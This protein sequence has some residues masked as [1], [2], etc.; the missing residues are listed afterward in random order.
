MSGRAALVHML[1]QQLGRHRPRFLTERETVNVIRRL[2]KHAVPSE[3][4]CCLWGG[5]V[6]TDGYGRMN[7]WL[8]GRGRFQISVHRLVYQ[9]A[10]DPRDI[11]F[12]REVAHDCDTPPCFHP[13]HVKSQR[14]PD[15]RRRS[16]ENTNRKKALRRSFAETSA[17]PLREA[18]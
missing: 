12:Y 13:G 5:A 10:H 16:A 17:G 11:P 3:R 9:L 1:C 6:T 14:R 7:V 18:A 4:G 15:N 2:I 8:N